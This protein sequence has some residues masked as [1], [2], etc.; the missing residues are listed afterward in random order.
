[1][2]NII[3]DLGLIFDEDIILIEITK[4]AKTYTEWF[5]SYVECDKDK[6]IKVE[7]K[8]DFIFVSSPMWN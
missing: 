1:M 3:F 8:G 7:R 2:N 4:H 6:L 5:Y